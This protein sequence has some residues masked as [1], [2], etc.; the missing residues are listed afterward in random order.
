MKRRSGWHDYTRRQMYMVTL[1]T[2]GRRKLFG[3]VV[4]R[5]EALPGAEDAPRMVL[6]A[7]GQRVEEEFLGVTRYYPQVEVVA[8]QMMP[9]HLH[10]ILFVREEMP[11]GLGRL[12]N[13][14]KA[15]CNRAYREME[16]AAEPPQLTEPQGAQPPLT[17][18]QGQQQ[19]QGQ[20]PPQRAAAQPPHRC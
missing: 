18:P 3:E 7:F 19:G 15:G 6:S 1:T 13:G 9:D 8:L 20:Q 2:E 12:I 5:S 14:F 4:G 16:A 11:A 17:E 10:G